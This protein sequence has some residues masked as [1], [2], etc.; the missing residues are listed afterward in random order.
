MVIILPAFFFFER[1]QTFV[2]C[3][4]AKVKFRR[5][6]FEKFFLPTT[7]KKYWRLRQPR[8]AGVSPNQPKFPPPVCEDAMNGSQVLAVK[9]LGNNH[10][11]NLQQSDWAPYSLPCW[12]CWPRRLRT[13]QD[14][15]DLWQSDLGSPKTKNMDPAGF[16]K[17]NFYF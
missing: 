5:R 12:S 2:V 9:T 3:P 6:H 14:H 10:H 15:L 7:P 13:R 17:P 1:N 16:S 11:E 4:S 8:L